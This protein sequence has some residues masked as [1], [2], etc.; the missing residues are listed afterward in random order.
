VHVRTDTTTERDQAATVLDARFD[1]VR[2]R[3]PL[4]LTVR[5]EH[6]GHAADIL[7]TLHQAGV[8]VASS[9]F[10]QPSLDEV[11]LELT[12]RPAEPST[13]HEGD[14]SEVVA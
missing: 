11:F 14:P 12:G 13:P 2:E 6:A 3:D 5:A 7:S 9:S 4:A 8:T 1:V 10:G